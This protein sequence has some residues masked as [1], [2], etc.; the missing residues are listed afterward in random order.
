MKI[1]DLVPSLKT[2]RA[3]Q[4]LG[5][6]KETYFVWTAGTE[7]Y[8]EAMPAKEANKDYYDIHCAPTV[9]EIGKVLPDFI[10]DNQFSMDRLGSK[11]WVSYSLDGMRLTPYFRHKNMAQCYANLIIWLIENDHIKL[12]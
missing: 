7:N 3:L 10:G 9:S 5:W 8:S 6:K 4:V 11:W 1:S 2:C 12:E